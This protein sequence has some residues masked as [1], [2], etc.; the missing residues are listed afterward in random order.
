MGQF[1]QLA[2]GTVQ[3]DEKLPIGRSSV[4]FFE[5]PEYTEHIVYY[6]T[7]GIGVLNIL[8]RLRAYIT[9]IT[10]LKRRV[11]SP[12]L[13]HA[14]VIH[15]SGIVAFALKL[16]RKYRYVISEHSTR[17]VPPNRLSLGRR[18]VARLVCRDA[19]RV[20]PVSN[21]L[22]ERMM[23]RVG[24]FVNFQVVSNV[25]NTE[26]FRHEPKGGTSG[27]QKLRVLHVSNFKDHQKNM[28]GL[29]ECFGKVAKAFPGQV[30][31][32]IAGDGDKNFVTSCIAEQDVSSFDI[33]VSGP[34]TDIEIAALMRAADVFV[35]FSNF[36]TQGLVLLEALCTGL[37]CIGPEVGPIPEIIH[38]GFNGLLVATGNQSSLE[39]ALIAF[40][41]KSH[42]YFKEKIAADASARYGNRVI[43]KKILSVYKAS[44]ECS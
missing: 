38:P 32:V 4:A 30:Q 15:D 16:F 14:N 40:I 8:N 13:V 41:T 6:G 26:L 43:G 31:F 42:C 9:L 27:R 34:H 11:G 1:V 18:L 44:I 23:D 25:V 35:L 17:F 36:E 39:D 29:I 37:P 22:Q 33:S 7:G 21:Y 20:L 19:E 3:A 28:I 12:D 2:V 24:G 5:A 10:A